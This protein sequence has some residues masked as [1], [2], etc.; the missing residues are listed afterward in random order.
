MKR[1]NNVQLD[2]KPMRIEVVGTNIEN[3]VAFPP[4]AHGILGNPNGIPQRYE[5]SALLMT[6]AKGAS[7][8][9]LYIIVNVGLL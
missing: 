8:N 5:I 2:G 7:F 9:L 6:V 1:Y 4:V 3:P